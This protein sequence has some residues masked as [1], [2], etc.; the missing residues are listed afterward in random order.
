[1]QCCQVAVATTKLTIY[2]PLFKKLRDIIFF[3]GT[4]TLWTI[5]RDILRGQGFFDPLNCP[6]LSEMVIIKYIVRAM[7]TWTYVQ[8]CVQHWWSHNVLYNV[9]TVY[10]QVRVHW[11]QSSHNV[12]APSKCPEKWL[13]KWLS[14]KKNYVP[15]RTLVILCLFA[16]MG[17]QL[18]PAAS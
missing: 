5:S 14:Q 12:E 11:V 2:V 16:T 18:C 7:H 8:Y 3:L 6:E 17:P 15:K 13:I 9:C 10:I 4:I 1:M